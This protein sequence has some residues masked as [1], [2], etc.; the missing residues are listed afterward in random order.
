MVH[1]LLVDLEVG[2]FPVAPDRL[3]ANEA[4][5]LV[6]VLTVANL[7]DALS[8]ESAPAVRQNCWHF[9][10]VIERLIAHVTLV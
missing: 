7:I 10:F 1:E 3:R 4:A 8:A 2:G 5:P 9:L 6:F